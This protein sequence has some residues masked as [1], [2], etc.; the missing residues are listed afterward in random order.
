VT[1]PPPVTAPR[2]GERSRDLRLDVVVPVWNEEQALDL[3]FRRLEAVF[4]PEAR[5]SHGIAAVRYLFVDDGSQDR[6]AEI[7]TER[8]R[9]GAGAVLLRLSRN[10]GH[11]SAVSAGLDHVTAD[12][13]AVIDADLQDPPE[14]ILEMVQRWRE[15]FDVVYGVRR[16]RQESLL[17]RAG[18]WSF[19]RLVA[20][21]SEIKIPLDGGDFCLIDAR[22]I[23]VLRRLPEKLRFPRGLRAWVGFRQTGVEYD[24]P[25][26]QAGSSKYTLRRLYKL[27]TDGVISSSLRPLQV[28]QVASVTYLLVIL[29]LGLFLAVKPPQLDLPPW[30]LLLYLLILSGNFV[31]ALCIYILG[32]YVGRTYLEVK[33]RPAYVVMEVVGDTPGVLPGTRE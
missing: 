6:S 5:E 21:L 26:R 18:Y 20:F 3:L 11:Q 29:G 17:R 7:V 2:S 4:S 9:Q 33:G 28:A 27:A 32:A 15:G 23:A 24:R 14:L 22:V 19:Y 8:I 31:Q 1:L 13:A 10:F 25:R 12:L 16:K 30:I